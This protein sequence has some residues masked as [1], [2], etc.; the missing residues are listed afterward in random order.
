ML[1]DDYV[2]GGEE[3]LQPKTRGNSQYTAHTKSAADRTQSIYEILNAG[4]LNSSM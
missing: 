4:K 3:F 1:A 2:I